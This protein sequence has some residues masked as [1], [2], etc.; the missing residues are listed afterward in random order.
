MHRQ[1]EARQRQLTQRQD[2]QARCRLKDVDA[3]FHRFRTTAESRLPGDEPRAASQEID[4]HE[5]REEAA[6]EGPEGMT[7]DEIDQDNGHRVND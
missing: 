4:E 6:G 3:L 5:A 2:P 1:P 7:T